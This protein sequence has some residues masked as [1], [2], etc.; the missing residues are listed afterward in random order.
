[1]C[2]FEKQCSSSN[3]SIPITTGTAIS[4]LFLKRSS[5]NR[6]RRLID[7]SQI[8]SRPDLHC[9]GTLCR[10]RQFAFVARQ[11]ELAIYRLT[12]LLLLRLH[13]WIWFESVSVF[14]A[15]CSVGEIVV[16]KHEHKVFLQLSCAKP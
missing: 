5:R 4:L 7:P 3:S 14:R 13:G 1:V 16:T 6:D 10:M 2:A 9:R 8:H 11:F 12:T 15:H